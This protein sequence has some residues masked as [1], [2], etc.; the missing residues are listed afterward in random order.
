MALLASPRTAYS[1]QRL[2]TLPKDF[3]LAILLLAML[4]ALEKE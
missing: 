3:E 4:E 1:R 2:S